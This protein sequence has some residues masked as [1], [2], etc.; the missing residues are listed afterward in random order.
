MSYLLKIKWKHIDIEKKLRSCYLKMSMNSN[1]K[2]GETASKKYIEEII[3]LKNQLKIE[4][5]KNGILVA[6][7]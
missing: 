3:A 7:I 6:K 1:K 4:K 2:N 5:E